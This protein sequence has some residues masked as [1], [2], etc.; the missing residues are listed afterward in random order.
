MPQSLHYNNQLMAL[1]DALTW[2]KNVSTNFHKQESLQKIVLT[3]RQ[4]NSFQK[5]SDLYPFV[6]NR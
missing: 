4:E 1:E 2:M 6:D 5:A 3:W